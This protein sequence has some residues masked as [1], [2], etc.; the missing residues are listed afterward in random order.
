MPAKKT[1]SAKSSSVHILVIHGP[2]LN[3]L[4]ARE[5]SI[6]GHVTMKNINEELSAESK[7]LGV[8]VTF[9]QSNHE[10]KIVDLVGQARNKY[11]GILINPAAYTHTSVAIRDALLAASLPAVEVHLS[12]IYKREEF[13]QHSLTA[14]ACLGQ[15]AGFGNESYI[16]GL[17]ALVSSLKKGIT[18]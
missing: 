7:K 2:N 12:N 11:Q 15:V 13:R 10:G 5:V 14:A 3:L 6:Y 17:R 9:A 1:S 4:G 8:K 16:L 18:K